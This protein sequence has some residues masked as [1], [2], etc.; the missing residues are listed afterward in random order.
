M[1]NWIISETVF[2]LYEADG[3]SIKP[4]KTSNCCHDYNHLWAKQIFK[5]KS[6]RD[7]FI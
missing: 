5:K 7:E 4:Q 2:A 6:L 3:S 1:S